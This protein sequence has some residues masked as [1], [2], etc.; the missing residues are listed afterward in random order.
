MTLVPKRAARPIAY[1]PATF[2][3]SKTQFAQ[4]FVAALSALCEGEV[5]PSADMVDNWFN[6]TDVDSL[7]SWVSDA[8]EFGWTQAIAVIDAATIIAENPPEGREGHAPS[9]F[10]KTDQRTPVERFQASQTQFTEELHAFW[11]ERVVPA[12]T[13]SCYA[14]GDD[15]ASLIRKAAVESLTLVTEG[16]RTS[17][18]FSADGTRCCVRVPTKTLNLVINDGGVPRAPTVGELRHFLDE[19]FKATAERKKAIQAKIAEL[20]AELKSLE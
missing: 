4:R 5:P 11:N 17:I 15:R 10:G 12:I 18:F 2:N 3:A 7:Q 20:D 8:V 14:D 13:V 6:G 1:I 9:P 16:S 19:E